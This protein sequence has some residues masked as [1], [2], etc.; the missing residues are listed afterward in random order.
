VR[1][2]TLY[3]ARAVLLILLGLL[4]LGIILHPAIVIAAIAGIAIVLAFF[5]DPNRT[6][7]ED[8]TAIFSAADGTVTAIEQVAD[9]NERNLRVS[10]FLSVFNVHINRA[11]VA[12]TIEEIEWRPGKFHDARSDSAASQNERQ[13][14]LFMTKFGSVRMRQIAG[15]I[16]RRSVAWKRVGDSVA[17][18]ERVGMIRFGSRTDLFLPGSAIPEV[19]IGDRV[20]AGQTIVARFVI[21]KLINREHDQK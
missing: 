8:T 14:W 1:F 2:Q 3:E 10:V 4:G 9:F 13:D 18:G 7:P 12:G 6:T 19:K 11:P 21:P 5:R 17:A 16:A 20:K 15:L